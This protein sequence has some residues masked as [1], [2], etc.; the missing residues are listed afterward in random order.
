M[1]SHLSRRAFLRLAA[2]SVAGVTLVACAPAITPVESEAGSG[3]A[4]ETLNLRMGWWGGLSRNEL[5]N[6]ICDLYEQQNPGTTIV[7]EYAAWGDYWT[8]VAT[9]AAGGN[10]PDI[11][12][13]VIDT[14]SEY[15]LRG[16]YAALDPFIE[17]GVIETADWDPMVLNSGK[18]AGSVYFMATGVTSNCVIVNEDL[19]KRVGLEPPAF[20][21]SF[22]E[23]D[24]L[25]HAIQAVLPADTWATTNGGGYSEHFQSWVLQKGYQIANEDATD[26]GFPKEVMVEF[27]E[28]WDRLYKDGLVIPIE[29]SSQPLG[30][31][32]ADSFLA[33][34][35]VAMMYINSNQ[36]K[37]FQQYTEDNLVIMRNPMMP[38]G[39]NRAGEYLRPSAL[40]IASNS[41]LKEETAAFINFFVN[42]VEATKIFNMELGAVG[43]AHV[44][45]ML[46][47]SIHPKDVEVIDHF[48]AILKDIPEKIP[49]PKGTA[50]VLAAHRR[51]SEA[52]AYGTS[53]D[54]AV[55]TFL[56][57]AAD[58]YAVNKA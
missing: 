18:V 54:E 48:N 5:Y 8:K 1:K 52:I 14:L 20:E 53:I 17:S 50:A 56:T 3:A 11:T 10:L 19:I 36:L 2:G 37:I 24:Q 42:D 57:E 39:V 23:F 7:R 13:S 46:R 58:A 55:D 6:S 4:A 47:E 49:D 35:Q 33:K 38:E 29:I 30:D 25:A 22:E 16:A 44:Q 51:A 43:P 26:V 28:Y 34:G 45:D 31:A 27:F 32:W 21:T 12:A 9:Q 40:S 15:A 41:E